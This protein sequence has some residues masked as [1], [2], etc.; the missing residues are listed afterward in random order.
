MIEERN[1]GVSSALSY[2]LVVVLTVSLT[3][4]LVI[5][6]NSM[7]NNQREEVAR[8]QIDAIGQR[9]ASTVMVIDR[10]NATATRP[11][12]ASVTR[13]FPRRVAG[14]QYRI[15]TVSV[16]PNHWRLYL[17]TREVAINQSFTV[18]L[19]SGLALE[20]TTVNG[21]PVRVFYDRH[22]SDPGKDTVGIDHA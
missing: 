22:P 20:E 13:E 18:R 2:A 17:E 3:A 12:T 6:T 15:R 9:L 19:R 4:S 14:M 1:R 11:E 8:D 5:G 16:G 21:G 10:L 7:I